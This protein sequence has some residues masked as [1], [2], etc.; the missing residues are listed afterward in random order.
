LNNQQLLIEGF[1][2]ATSSVDGLVIFDGHAVIFGQNTSTEIPHSV[3]QAMQC[4]YMIVA[5]ANPCDIHQR[6]LHDTDRVRPLIDVET[7]DRQQRLAE[8]A[9]A[10]VAEALGIP[11]YVNDVEDAEAFKA[12]L[13][14]QLSK[15]Y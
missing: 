9:A 10:R 15:G 13:A 11:F 3:F 2:R 8:T 1:R 4:A 5:K 12:I 14:T 6:R 7:L